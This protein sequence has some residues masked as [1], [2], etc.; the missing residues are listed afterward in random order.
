MEQLRPCLKS[1]CIAYPRRIIIDEGKYPSFSF[2]F[3]IS[4]RETFTWAS[5]DHR[6]LSLTP[7]NILLWNY[8]VRQILFSQRNYNSWSKQ[9]SAGATILPWSKSNRSIIK[10]LD[11]FFDV[12]SAIKAPDKNATDRYIYLTYILFECRDSN[13]EQW[14][15]S[16][17]CVAYLSDLKSFALLNNV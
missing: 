1:L 17:R 5:N 12:P 6:S 11:F 4:T 13:G 15:Q 9:I 7:A 8:F 3:P 2:Q 10:S 16:N 14:A